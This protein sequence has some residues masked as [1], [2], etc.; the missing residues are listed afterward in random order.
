[1]CNSKLTVTYRFMKQHLL[2]VQLL[3]KLDLFKAATTHF[4]L[5]FAGISC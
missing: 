1:M 3:T 2:T 5:D 4:G